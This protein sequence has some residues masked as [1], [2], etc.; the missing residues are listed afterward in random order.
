[1]PAL[2]NQK[3]EA[4]AR[5]LAHDKSDEDASRLAGYP[6]G[7]SFKSNARKRAQRAD[8]KARVLELRA[9]GIAAAEE[10]A[11]INTE[12]VLTKAA[13]IVNVKKPASAIKVSDQV[14]A[15]NLIAKVIG[16][17]APDKVD[18]SGKI[19]IE[20]AQPSE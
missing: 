15:L 18:N 6:D 11:A 2:R 8:V 17:M 5:E 13:N 3:L 16:A 20:W 1:M 9:P 12:Y 7:T 19:V 14:A 4:V 10:H